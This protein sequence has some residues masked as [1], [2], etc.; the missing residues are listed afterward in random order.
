MVV[1][2][3]SPVPSD[4]ASLLL[5]AV[6][7]IATG[8]ALFIVFHAYRGY[9]RNESAR[10]LYLASGLCLITVVPLALSGA[11]NAAGHMTALPPRSYTFYLPLVS[12]LSEIAGLVALLYSLLIVPAESD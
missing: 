1:R 11:F 3:S 2:Q 12:R 6:T 10:M 9:R 5:L 8:L 4:S 7:L